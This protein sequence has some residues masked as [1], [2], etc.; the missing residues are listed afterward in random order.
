MEARLFIGTVVEDIGVEQLKNNYLEGPSNWFGDMKEGDLVI[1]SENSIVSKLLKVRKIEDIANDE[2]RCYFDVL[3]EYNPAIKS[4]IVFASKY[5]KFDLI[6]FNN[7]YKPVP[8]SSKKGHFYKPTIVE[9]YENMDIQD[10]EFNEENARNIYVTEDIRKIKDKHEGDIF[11][12]VSDKESGYLIKETLEYNTDG[13]FNKINLKDINNTINIEKYSLKENLDKS[14]QHNYPKKVSLIRNIISELEDKGFYRYS[15]T[16]NMGE[17]YNILIVQL[18]EKNNKKGN[19]KNKKEN[20]NI[21]K[22]NLQKEYSF[23]SKDEINKIKELLEFKKNIILEGVPGVGKTYIAEKIAEDIVEGKKENIEIIQFHQSYSYEDF[24]EG[25]RPTEDGSHFEPYS[26]ILKTLCEKAK[27]RIDEKFVVIIDE[28]N[29]GN[30][31]KIFGETF[32][33]IE[34]DKRLTEE[35]ILNG[36]NSKYAVKL[37]YSNDKFDIPENVYFIGTMNTIDRSIALFDIALRRRFANYEIKPCFNDR[38]EDVKKEIKQ[39]LKDVNSEKLELLWN[40]IKEIDSKPDDENEGL[41]IGHSYLCGL[42]NV[43]KEEVD[44]KIDLILNYEL[45]PQIREYFIGNEEKIK[46]LEKYFSF[47]NTDTNINKAE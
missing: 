3:K 41:L 43:P 8:K 5:F 25:L 19:N 37:P 6:T 42:Q 14:K 35:Q 16:S 36:E 46:K 18:K 32:M 39:Y 11:F 15:L 2:K 12:I 33:L 13:K 24:I 1:P 17:F 27:E 4:R 30:I 22:E 44:E 21:S 29:R 47:S 23:I 28:I 34:K 7:A 45:L 20:K 26:G 38:H 10:F 31:S 40:K 9:K